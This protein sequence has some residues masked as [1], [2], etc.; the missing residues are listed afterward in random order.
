MEGTNKIPLAK[1][2]TW[3]TLFHQNNGRYLCNPTVGVENVYVSYS[4]DEADD[5]KKLCESHHRL[6]TPIVET[7]RG[8]WKKLINKFSK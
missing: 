2:A 7:K 8:F 4:F 3:L 1:F 6:T 5:Y